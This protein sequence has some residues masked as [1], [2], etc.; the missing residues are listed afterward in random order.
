MLE[1]VERISAIQGFDNFQK[2][3]LFDLTPEKYDI[4]VSIVV[5]SGVD[6]GK[7]KQLLVG[8]Y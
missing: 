2:Q 6:T 4:C 3:N 5:V 8:H 7:K 1:L